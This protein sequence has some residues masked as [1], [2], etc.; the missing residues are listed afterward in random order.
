MRTNRETR[1]TDVAD[2]LALLNFLADSYG[3]LRL[4]GVDLY[5]AKA[6]G[7]L[8]PQTECA[9]VPGRGH[10]STGGSNDRAAVA[11]DQVDAL[12]KMQITVERWLQRER[13]RPEPQ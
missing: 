10:L 12:V 6:V 11:G 5:E 4:V 1:I 13:G 8:N 7:H 9:Q 2:L 3:N